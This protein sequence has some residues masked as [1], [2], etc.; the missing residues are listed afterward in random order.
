MEPPL[1]VRTVPPLL[2]TSTCGTYRVRI[3][4]RCFR[5]MQRLAIEHCP[6]EVGTSLVGQY[7]P[8]GHEA[9]IV[10]IAPLPADSTLGRWC[11]TR[12]ILG[13]REF[14]ESVRRRFRG[15]RRRVGEWH[16][17]PCVAPIASGTDDYHQTELARSE[18]EKLSEAILVIL[19][20]NLE[21]K[22]SLGVYVYSR[23]RGRIQ[24]IPAT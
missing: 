24:L 6:N 19:G 8:D 17:H 15:R 10:T 9:I 1:Q 22:P 12:G 11:F 13:L 16:S 18:A 14:F 21:K 4:R 23:M 2:W 7:T 20:D 5:R 3:L